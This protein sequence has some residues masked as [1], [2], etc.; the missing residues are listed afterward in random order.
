MNS[1][2][3]QYQC[4]VDWNG[5][6]YCGLNLKWNYKEDLI[7]VK[8]KDYVRRSLVKL[9]HVPSKK[10]Q[11]PPHPWHTP[12][13]GKKMSQQPTAPYTAP[14][15]EKAGTRRI[16]DI[17]GTFLYYL[18]INQCIKTALTEIATKQSAPIEDTNQKVQM[19]MEHL[20]QYPDGTLR[21]YA[22]K[23]ILIYKADSTYLVLP[24]NR[25]RAAA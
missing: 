9:K 18:E 8:I 12:V 20:Y 2:K 25:F 24:K 6:L 4:T 1:V 23:M 21:Y 17:S 22:S 13:Y 7:N 3:L 14:L 10:P 15:L 16:Q 19:L 5:S 11:H